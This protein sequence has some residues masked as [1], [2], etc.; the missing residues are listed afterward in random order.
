MIGTLSSPIKKR[1]RLVQCWMHKAL[2]VAW[3][4]NHDYELVVIMIQVIS[5]ILMG[6][7]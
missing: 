3:E 5:C 6:T 2:V 4:D 1:K 7:Y